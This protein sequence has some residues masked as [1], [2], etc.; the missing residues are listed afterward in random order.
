MFLCFRNTGSEENKDNESE[1]KE[2]KGEEDKDDDSKIFVKEIKVSTLALI[3]ISS[4]V[5]RLI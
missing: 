5:Y 3:S 1:G 2:A 4:V